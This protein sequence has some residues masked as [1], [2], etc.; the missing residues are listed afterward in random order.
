M[1]MRKKITP[2]SAIRAKCIECCCGNAAEVRRCE[3]AD[4]AL[5]PYRS[6]H[7]PARASIGGNPRKCDFP[8]DSANSTKPFVNRNHPEYEN[9]FP[10]FQAEN[11]NSSVKRR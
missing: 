9:T 1:S 10:P 8:A 3:I 2:M 5:H 11:V 7:N 6:G 4:C